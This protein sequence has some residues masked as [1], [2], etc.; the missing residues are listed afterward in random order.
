MARLLD[1]GD[2]LHVLRRH[3]LLRRLRPA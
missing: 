1:L 3:H 2:D